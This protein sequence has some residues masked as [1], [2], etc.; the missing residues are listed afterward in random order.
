MIKTR[1][2]DVF[3]ICVHL[4]DDLKCLQVQEAVAVLQAYQAKI[5]ATTTKLDE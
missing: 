5:S 4:K 3:A 1:V 2:T